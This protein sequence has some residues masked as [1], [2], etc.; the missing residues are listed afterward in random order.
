MKRISA[1]FLNYKTGN[2]TCKI[3]GKKEKSEKFDWN[4]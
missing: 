1:K 2:H 4:I 3:F